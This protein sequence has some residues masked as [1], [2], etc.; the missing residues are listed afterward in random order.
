MKSFA[1]PLTAMFCALHVIPSAH[2]EESPQSPYSLSFSLGATS[3]YV[4]RGVSQTQNEPA[5]QGGLEFAHA[6]GIY[7]G[8]WGSNVAWVK[9]GGY[10]DDNSLEVDLYGG[11]RGNFTEDFG[12]DAGIITYY[13]PGNKISGATDPDTT[14][15]YAGVSWRTISF[16]Y[17]HAVSKHLFGWTA[18]DGGK[19]RG[20]YYLDLSGTYD[21]G[22]GWSVL[23]HVG[24]QDIK[25][26]DEASYTDW[27][28]GVSKDLGFGIVSLAYTDTDA[29]KSAYTWDGEKVADARV[30]L[31]F[32]TGF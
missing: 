28:L 16:K 22:S 20:S 12:Y 30:I 29:S 14:E 13:Y 17:S 24:Y 4:F 3:D 21:L 7:I 27:K 11:F 5:V 19:T 26:N 6:S 23:A 10:K 2:A 15:V 18:D 9:D 32:Q 31:S 25:D 8:L 1:L